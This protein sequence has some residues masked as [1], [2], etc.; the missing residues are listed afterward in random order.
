[1]TGSAFALNCMVEAHHV[2]VTSSTQPIEKQEQR[3]GRGPSGAKSWHCPQCT[4]ML[5]ATIATFGDGLV[6][7]R[8]GTLEDNDKLAPDGHFYVRSKHPVCKSMDER[9]T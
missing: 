2:K 7:L 1:M 3:L 6:F 4:V 8:A 9:T 5:Y